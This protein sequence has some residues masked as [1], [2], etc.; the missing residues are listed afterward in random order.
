MKK[1]RIK[2]VIEERGISQQWLADK[3]GKSYS[4]FNGYVLN[5]HQPKV[6]VL[7]KIAQLL[8]IQPNS[9][10]EEIDFS[11][12][13]GVISTE[14]LKEFDEHFNHLLK[15]PNNR[16]HNARDRLATAIQIINELTQDKILRQKKD[17]YEVMK[18][19]N[20]KKGNGYCSL[21][22][23]FMFLDSNSFKNG[24]WLQV[25]EKSLFLHLPLTKKIILNLLIDES[26]E[27]KIRKIYQVKD[28]NT[29]YTL[30]FDFKE[31]ALKIKVGQYDCDNI[32]SGI[33]EELNKL[34]FL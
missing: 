10:I 13:Q 28:F 14:N 27:E 4:V 26:F 1:N 17:I 31:D 5:K 23:M 2:I 12:F 20:E 15:L 11:Q 29:S 3:V 8:K 34:R 25:N 32:L 24:I 30:P 6:D 19:S 33:D 21:K 18:W 22:I 7:F 9:L 16:F